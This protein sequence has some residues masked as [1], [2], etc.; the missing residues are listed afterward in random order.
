M[1]FE[2][3]EEV[4]NGEVYMERVIFVQIG[5]EVI[6]LDEWVCEVSFDR[7]DFLIGFYGIVIY[8][9]RKMRIIQKIRERRGKVK[10]V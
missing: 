5:F 3:M 10:R 8:R 7:E 9:D 2:I 6:G 4:G 1:S